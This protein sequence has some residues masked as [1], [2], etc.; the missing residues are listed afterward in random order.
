MSL[1]NFFLLLASCFMELLENQNN[2][3]YKLWQIKKLSD[4]ENKIR[5][6][7]YN[8]LPYTWKNIINWSLLGHSNRRRLPLS[9]K[10]SIHPKNLQNCDRLPNTLS[11]ITN[12]SRSNARGDA[13]DSKK[14]CW[15]TVTHAIIIRS[16]AHSSTAVTAIIKFGERVSV[17]A[18]CLV[19]PA[20]KWFWFVFAVLV[21]CAT[22][23]AHCAGTEC[24]PVSVI[25]GGQGRLGQRVRVTG[26]ERR[27]RAVHECII[28]EVKLR[29][30]M[31]HGSRTHWNMGRFSTRGMQGQS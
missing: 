24:N 15:C 12:Q 30:I 18:G 20:E 21:S 27:E 7:F 4:S 17:L 14:L 1:L 5:H 3:R 8:I 9:D 19:S 16:R 10:P 6:I 22:R 13:H 25:G 11:L 2:S 28:R 29:R 31:C 26:A 23:A